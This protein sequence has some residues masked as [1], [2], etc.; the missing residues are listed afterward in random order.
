MVKIHVD[1]RALQFRK[2]AARSVDTL[3]FDTAL[4]DH[5]GKYVAG[6]ESTLD[7]RLTDAKLEQLEH[8][9]INAETNFQVAPG[10][11]RVRVVVRDTGTKNM[12]ALNGNVEVTAA[13]PVQ[14]AVLPA[15]P[16]IAAKHKKEKKTKSMLDWSTAEFIKAMPELRGLDP[17]GSQERLGVLL[18]RTGENVKSFFDDFPDIASRE[19]IYLERLFWPEHRTEEFSYLALPLPG[20]DRVELEEYRTNAAGKRAE[21]RALEHG[22]VT[23]GFVSM[24]V[25]FHPLYLSES[26]F[27]Y[28][29]RQNMDG[30]PVDVVC[31]AQIP[32]KARVKESLK[33]EF[34]SLAITLQ[35]VAWIDSDAYHIVRMRTELEPRADL[36]LKEETTELRFTEVRFKDMPQVFWLPKEVTVTVNWD[37]AVFRNRHVYSEFQLFRVNTTTEPRRST[38]PN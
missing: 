16:A 33:T 37:G 19:R 8:S 20:K 22:F 29:G 35:G 17:A 7:F 36:D 21:P 23:E 30:H 3:T 4:F 24:I 12:A 1:T 14:T 10:P 15:V 6:K 18:E 38:P 5:D 27:R 11:Y 34:R 26:R 32:G 2:D 13:P 25:H 9:G 28:L 31:F